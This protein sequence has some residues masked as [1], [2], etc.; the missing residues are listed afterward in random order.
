MQERM[1]KVRVVGG[2]LA[3]IEAAHL[4][5]KNGVP[6]DLFEMRP[7]TM[8]PAHKTDLLAEL[9]CSNSFKGTDPLTAHGILKREMTGLGSLTLS[10]ASE[11]KVPAGK[12]L[13]VDRKAFAT[14]ITGHIAGE[15]L[16]IIHREELRSI[17][18]DTPTIIA[19]GPLT[20][21]ALT[22]SL[23]EITGSNRLFFY[24]A[25]S[26]IIDADSID[27]EHAF[28]GARWTDSSEDYLNCPLDEELYRRFAEEL[29]KAE[30]VR[31]H[32]FEDVRYF[33][34]CLPIEIVAARGKDTL[35]FGTMRPVGLV[36]PSTGK[37]PYAVIQLRRENLRGNAYAMVG[38][39][40][41]L[42]YPE[43]VR[44]IH[45]IPA[46]ASA[47]LLRHGS[48]HR[49]TYLD[50]PRILEQDLSLKGLP[51]LFLAGQITGVEGYMESAAT[52]IL[53]GISMLTRLKGSRLT[54]PGADTAL[55]ALINYIT[56]RNTTFFQPTNIN[57][58]IM[59]L[60][61]APKKKRNEVRSE[62]A[63]LSFEQW[64]QGLSTIRG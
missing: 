22:A 2:G 6:V 63:A 40:T 52:G 9:V 56:D 47:R 55:G 60:P 21:D 42:T 37:R 43:Q 14:S 20:S 28:Y 1:D 34:A 57:F 16:I 41:R 18:G 33:E 54:P 23:A 61:D 32:A 10:V 11:T 49:N 13:A 7:G 3:G 44:I 19:T 35:R 17:D 29:L 4:I 48:I 15:P 38:F 12:A 39:Q 62:R 51:N 58:G 30:Q 25:I 27:M 64:R 46:L 53:S 8:T 31:S 24:D 59:E 36:N 5:A 26:P 50:S 45:M